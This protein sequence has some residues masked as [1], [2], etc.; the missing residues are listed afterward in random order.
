MGGRLPVISE[1][2]LSLRSRIGLG[3]VRDGGGGHA[4]LVDDI[5]RGYF[6]EQSITR[7]TIRERFETWAGSISRDVKAILVVGRAERLG[8]VDWGWR[9]CA[10]GRGWGRLLNAHS[11]WQCM[12]G[13]VYISIERMKVHAAWRKIKFTSRFNGVLWC[14]PQPTLIWNL[15]EMRLMSSSW[16]GTSLSSCNKFSTRVNCSGSLNLC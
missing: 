5:R 8:C 2:V 10:K 13:R 14:I 7:L 15:I 16:S 1:V 12:R 11:S 4:V 3:H 6:S 9:G